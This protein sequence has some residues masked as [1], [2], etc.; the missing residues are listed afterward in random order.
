VLAVWTPAEQK[1]IIP[2][3]AEHYRHLF[4][5]PTT[6]V[7]TVR[8]ERTFWEKATILHHEA[9]RPANS[10]TPE[11]Y[12]RHYYDMYRLSISWVKGNA[13]ADLDLL[14][15]VVDFKIKFYPRSWAKYEYAVPGSIN[16]MPPPQRLDSL[17]EDYGHMLGMLF[18]HKPGFDEV[19]DGINALE[20]EIN[21][22]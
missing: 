20:T 6:S 15:R 9:N 8:P 22:L 12:S 1:E 18:G 19:M 4:G 14:K 17:K 13:L 11:R 16:L 5:E 7:L 2:Y 10:L 21:H 3:A